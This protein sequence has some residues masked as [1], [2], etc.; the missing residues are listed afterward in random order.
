MRH[1]VFFVS[2]V[3]CVVIQSSFNFLDV[4]VKPDFLLILVVFIALMEGPA[5]G[6]KTGFVVGL[7]ED[8]V[9]GKYFGIYILCKMLTGLIIGLLEPKIFK[10]NY[11]IPVV[12][13]FFGTILHEFLFILFGNM[14]GIK[15]LWGESIRHQAFPLAIY[16]AILAPFAY[17]LFYKIY[18]SKWFNQ[19]R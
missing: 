12:T 5:A 18:V 13:L 15:I 16:H 7:V 6:L 2:I 8:I 10:E 19:S 11:L 1:F 4:G 3:L 9:A 17:V 14:I